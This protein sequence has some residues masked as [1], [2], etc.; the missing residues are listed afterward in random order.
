MRYNPNLTWCEP[1][2]DGHAGTLRT[3]QVMAWL[4]RKDSLDQRTGDTLQQLLAA[5]PRS[6]IVEPLFLFARDGIRYLPDPQNLEKVSDFFHTTA[7]KEGDC[8]DKVVWLATALL[9]LGVPVRFVVQ[10]SDV[11]SWDHVCLEF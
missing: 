2:A 3:L 6:Q 4:A 7:S 8:D 11:S 10:S 1:L 9:C 5:A